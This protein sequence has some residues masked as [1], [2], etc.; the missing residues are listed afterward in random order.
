MFDH[1]VGMPRERQNRPRHFRI[2]ENEYGLRRASSDFVV[3]GY[4]LQPGRGRAADE[5]THDT[6]DLAHDFAGK[7]DA[8]HAGKD[9]ANNT[10]NE[11]KEPSNHK[12]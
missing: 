6:Q 5:A 3:N 1:K 11:D 2:F 8:D 9:D 4:G 12:W 10:E 7:G